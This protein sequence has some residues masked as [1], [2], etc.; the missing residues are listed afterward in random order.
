MKTDEFIF[1]NYFKD[2][3]SGTMVEVG[4]AGPEF[5]SQ[6]NYFRSLGWRCIC[7]EPNPKFV[8]QHIEVGNEIYQ[9]ACSNFNKNDVDFQIV[10]VKNGNI[11]NESFSSLDIDDELIEY[12]GYFGGRSQFEIKNI[13]I[14]VRTLDFI[15]EES[16][17]DNIDYVIVD[18][19]GSELNV[20]DGFNTK[21]YNPKVIVLENNIP[22]RKN[23]YDSFMTDREFVFHSISDQC[24]YVYFNKNYN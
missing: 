4:S 16:K 7:I 5:L 8:S 1:K 24:N 20:I 12:S 15:L 22:S 11:S 3:S 21:K 6:S 23:K 13:K 9:Y 2:Y 17:V 19:E 14:N 18:V 10:D